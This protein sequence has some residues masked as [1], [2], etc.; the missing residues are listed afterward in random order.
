MAEGAGAEAAAD[1]EEGR[2][3]AEAQ[4]E[5]LRNKKAVPS[6]ERIDSITREVTR[7]REVMRTRELQSAPS[8][9]TEARLHQKSLEA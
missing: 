7:Q 1:T 6:L 4:L 9:L 8:S 3:D 2:R 5:E